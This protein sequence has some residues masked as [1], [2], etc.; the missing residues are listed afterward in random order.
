MCQHNHLHALQLSAHQ[1]HHSVGQLRFAHLLLFR[2]LTKTAWIF[3]LRRGR[4]ICCLVGTS[5]FLFFLYT[6]GAQSI[7]VDLVI[8]RINVKNLMLVCGLL[9]VLLDCGKEIDVDVF[10]ACCWSQL[11]HKHCYPYFPCAIPCPCDRG[12]SYPTWCGQYSML[13]PHSKNFG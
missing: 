11:L 2:Q 5:L 10:S 3:F 8:F 7:Y 9:V 12:K 13:L 1:G 6:V 4:R